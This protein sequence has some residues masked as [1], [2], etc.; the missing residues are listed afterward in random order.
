[1]FLDCFW[2]KWSLGT[3]NLPSLQQISEMRIW[4][5]PCYLLFF[6]LDLQNK[7]CACHQ[8]IAPVFDTCSCWLHLPSALATSTCHL[9][10]PLVHATC[11]CHLHVPPALA[12]CTCHLHQLSWMTQWWSTA[13]HWPTSHCQQ[14]HGATIHMMLAL[15]LRAM[16]LLLLIM[17]NYLPPPMEWTA[18]RV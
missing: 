16:P 8:Q 2:K 9:H 5:T 17:G 4:F 14:V 11:T 15:G 12:T 13:P 1:M 18:V 3:A 6:R 7:T 10:L